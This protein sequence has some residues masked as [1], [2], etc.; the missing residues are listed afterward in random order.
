LKTVNV[1]VTIQLDIDGNTDKLTEVQNALFFINQ[2]LA[3]ET[4]MN[5]D[6]QIMVSGLDNSDIIDMSDGFAIGDEVEVP[7]PN[8]TDI[9]N[10][11]FVGTII[12]F[13]GENAI[14]EDGEGDC[15]EIETDRLCNPYN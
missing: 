7:E 4:N 6:A 14:V 3:R 8:D 1:N 13:R 11:S 12:E 5:Y 15:F 9:H 2:S 10:H